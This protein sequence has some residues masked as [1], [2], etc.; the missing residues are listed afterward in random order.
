MLNNQ[1]AFI[2]FHEK[3]TDGWTQAQ[4]GPSL[5]MPL[6]VVIDVGRPFVKA[7]YKIEG[8]EALVFILF[9]MALRHKC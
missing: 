5:A 6:A 2:A 9:I 8:D 4:S 3:V 7:T 1:C